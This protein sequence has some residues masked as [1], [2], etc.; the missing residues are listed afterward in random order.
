M[1]DDI[2]NSVFAVFE[3]FNVHILCV[4]LTWPLNYQ[5]SGAKETNRRQR[6]IRPNQDRIVD[7]PMVI[8][9]R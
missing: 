5:Y 3:R 7:R 6:K 1:S 9:N 4:H 8:T 2:F